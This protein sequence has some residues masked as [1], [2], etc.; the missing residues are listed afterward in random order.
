MTAA[1]HHERVRVG[2]AELAVAVRGTGEA[3]LLHPSL[4]RWAH[5]FDLLADALADA[6]YQ[7]LALDPRGVGASAGGLDG[8]TLP[9]CSE[10]IVAVL[11]H[12]G[13]GAAHLVGHAL[14][15]RIVRQAA[16]LWPEV[17]RTVILLAA[18]G[19]VPGDPEATRAVA[20]CFELDLPHDERMGAVALA[21]F[22]PGN[23]PGVWV[24]GW[25]P[26][27]AGAQGQ[28][29]MA[30]SSTGWWEGGAGPMLVVQG[31]QD[32]VA[33]PANGRDLAANRTGPT[34]VL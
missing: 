9:R 24:D 1:V 19:R 28:A 6:G 25:Y 31:L 15:N 16:T 23:D 33:P 12:L 30:S 8:L 14:G 5:D 26:A 13:I 27:A 3:V 11:G 4:G 17:T 20:R 2:D 10:D 22:A 34:G 32:R 29:S 7:S 21:F 18:G